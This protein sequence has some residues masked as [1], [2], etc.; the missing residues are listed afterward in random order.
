MQITMELPADELLKAVEQLSL[1]DLEQFVQQTV[2]LLAR[3]RA[4]VLPRKEAELLLKINQTAPPL[5]LQARY[6]ELAA[7]RQAETL[8][9][10]EHEELMHLT[11]QLD[12]LNVHRLE[13]LAELAR[14]RQTSLSVLMEDLGIEAPAVV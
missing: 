10:G 12:E 4:P 7:K 8:T 6:D 13:Y 5:D 2:R 3:R 11:D 1:P 9:P 14:L